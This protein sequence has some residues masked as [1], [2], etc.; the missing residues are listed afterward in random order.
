VFYI[1][2][3]PDAPSR[4][5]PKFGEWHHWLVVNIPGVDVA[6]GDVMS[7]YI[8]AG[9]PKGTKLHRYVYLI[10]KQQGKQD[11]KG[12]SK[13]TKFSANGRPCWKVREF[14]KKHNLGSAIAGNFFHAEYD[15]YC[16]EL[17]KQFKD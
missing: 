14:A 2:T 4:E 9:P 5:D 8:G 3:D 17:Y 7:E 13:L 16:D 15:S 10:F 1:Y 12:L 6:Q 11:F